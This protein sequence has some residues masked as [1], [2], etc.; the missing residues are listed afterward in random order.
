M[1]FLT[2]TKTLILTLAKTFT[3]QS[4]SFLQHTAYKLQP[5]MLNLQ[6]TIYNLQTATAKTYKL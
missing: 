3:H 1:L 6:P 4:N 2:V 5:T